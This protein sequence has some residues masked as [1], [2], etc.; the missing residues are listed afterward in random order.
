METRQT[1]FGTGGCPY[2]TDSRTGLQRRGRLSR[3]RRFTMPWPSLATAPVYDAVAVSRV[4]TGLQTVR[5]IH[6][7][8]PAADSPVS[9][10]NLT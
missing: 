2:S 8:A 1:L 3:P 10:F 7:S 6:L 5:L 9:D 4:R